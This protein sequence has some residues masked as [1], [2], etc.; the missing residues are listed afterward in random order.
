MTLVVSP[1]GDDTTPGTVAQPLRTIQA[2]ANLAQPGDICSVEAGVYRETVIPPRSGAA[3]APIVF[4]VAAGD[5]TG[6]MVFMIPSAEV[7][8][9]FTESRRPG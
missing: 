9:L 2:C 5:W 1:S 6:G 8:F 7:N 3:S 4:R